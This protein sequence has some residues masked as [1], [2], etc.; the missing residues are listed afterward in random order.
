M[1]DG[2][3]T[4]IGERGGNL[5][6]GQ[7]QRIALARAAYS[8]A[9]LHVLDS[10]LSAVDMYTCQ[11]TF[12]Y[13]IED[14]MIGGSGT[15]VLATHQTE[16]LS[17]SDHLIVM[18]NNDIVYNDK[19]VFEGIKHL[20]PSFHGDED[21][22]HISPS[23]KKPQCKAV[24]A[25]KRHMEKGMRKLVA[26]EEEKIYPGSIYVWYIKRMGVT[27]SMLGTLIFIITQIVRVYS[28]NWMSVW[29]KRT[30]E[31]SPC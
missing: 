27:A 28:D 18:E 3:Q 13:C 11:Y 7:K 21:S 1:A 23:E 25:E 4:W 14:M 10:P 20:F 17:M 15:V 6:G 29:S 2:D 30:Y 31:D 16:L 5:S 19:Y 24:P 22:L 12:K 9:D 8:Q 26:K